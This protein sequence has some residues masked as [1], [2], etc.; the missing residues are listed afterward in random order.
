MAFSGNT[1]VEKL[2]LKSLTPRAQGYTEEKLLL[3]RMAGA[4]RGD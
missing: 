3:A 4:A 2:R 1:R